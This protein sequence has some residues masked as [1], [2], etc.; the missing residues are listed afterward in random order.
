M[1]WCRANI[2]IGTDFDASSGAAARAL[3]ED[4]SSPPL[5]FSLRAPILSRAQQAAKDAAA[6]ENVKAGLPFNLSTSLSGYLLDL[7]DSPAY[8]NLTPNFLRDVFNPSTPDRP[9]VRYYSIAARTDKIGI[10][11]PLWLPKMVLDGAEA[12]RIAQ[13]AVPDPQ[14]RGND[15]LVNVESAKWGDFLGTL[16]NCDHWELRGS[17]GL[18]NAAA[19]AKMVAEATNLSSREEVDKG[20]ERG[21]SWQWQDVY[22]LVG[23]GKGAER[24]AQKTEDAKGVA[25]L[26]SWITRRLPIPYPTSSTTS[27]ADPSLTAAPQAPCIGESSTS[28]PRIETYSPA[29]GNQ[30]ARMLYGVPTSVS[31]P[32]KFNLERMA[33]AVCRKLHNEG[34]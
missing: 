31:K 9:D 2:G 25:S 27:T 34:F 17:S 18:I 1:A 19:T 12:A 16:E 3:H 20:K 22:A 14:W 15:G 32:D 11:H 8:A 6:A 5:P 29:T 23:K 24:E 7:L 33:L 21:K 26:A 4:A 28:A 30:Q 13:G 10:W